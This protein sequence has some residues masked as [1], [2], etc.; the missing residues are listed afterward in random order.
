[1]AKSLT[2]WLKSGSDDTLD[3]LIRETHDTDQNPSG[4]PCPAA[5]DLG[6][7]GSNQTSRM[8]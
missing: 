5:A 4:H 1:L 8:R 7:A 3:V 6:H 2:K